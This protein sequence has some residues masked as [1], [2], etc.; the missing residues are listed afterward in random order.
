MLVQ[1]HRDKRAAKCFF[2]KILEGL[3]Y[4][5]RRIVTLRSYGTARKEVLTDVIYDNDK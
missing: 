3:R 1:K 5:P 4:A 2:R